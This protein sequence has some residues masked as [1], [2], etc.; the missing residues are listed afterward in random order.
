MSTATSLLS[1]DF[2]A[3]LEQLELTSRRILAG[4]NKGDRLSKRKG[5]SIEFADHRHYVMGDDLRFLDW[6]LFAR[7]D[8]LFI[9]LFLEEEDLSLHLLIDGS[10]SMNFGT[11]T[12]LHLAKQL[13][14]ALGFIGLI[15]LDRVSVQQLGAGAAGVLPRLRGRT[16]VPRLMNFLENLRPIGRLSLR[17]GVRDFV[18][19]QPARGIAVIIS[20]FLDKDGYEE[21][22][23]LLVARRMEVY[24][25]HVL[26]PEELAPEV[27]GDLKL[28]DAEDGDVAEIT[29]TSYLLKRYK[30]NLEAFCGCLHQ[31]CAQR[32]MM[33]V[34]TS[35]AAPFERLVLSHL[36]GRG[37][38][39]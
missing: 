10:T 7:L 14:A 18:L 30:Q 38:L 19:R 15:N 33:Y 11:P 13:A 29:A 17:Q 32:N 5:T 21:A 20:D 9:K 26:A 24:V 31:F 4:R 22:L 12:K 36:R 27:V 1:P 37:L 2:M 8:R 3:R 16:H 23:R 39:R 28:V 34:F 35:S 25:I 6:N